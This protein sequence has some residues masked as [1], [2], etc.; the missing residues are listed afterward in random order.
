MAFHWKKPPQKPTKSHQKKTSKKDVKGH[1]FSAYEKVLAIYKNKKTSALNTWLEKRKISAPIIESAEICFSTPGLLT[2]KITSEKNNYPKYREL[3]GELEGS[4]LIR[5][6]RL[7]STVSGNHHLDIDEQYRDFFNDPRILLPIRDLNRRIVGF[8]GRKLDETSRAPKYLYTP[9][10]PKAQILYRAYEAFQKINS[11]LKNNDTPTLYICEGL[12]DALRL[13][14]L[15]FAAVSILGSKLSE[16]QAKTIAQLASTLPEI[17]PLQVRFFLDRDMAGLKGAASSIETLIKTD[18]DIRTEISFIWPNENHL[19]SEIA[20]GKDPDELF[21]FVED[22]KDAFEFLE[23]S[24]HPAAVAII[25]ER[26]KI[27]PLDVLD[28]S[29]WKSIP[30]GAKSRLSNH[31]AKLTN[32]ILSRVTDIHQ[33][34][35]KTDESWKSDITPVQQPTD[36]VSNQYFQ[37][38]STE[39]A[40]LRLNLAREVAHAGA[41][42]GE[43][44]SDIAGWRRISLAATAFNE[45]LSSRLTQN[46][47]QPIEPF[48]AAYVSR[49]FG[50][51]EE[52]LK[53]MPCPEDLII[54]QYLMN[55]LLTE[56]LDNNSETTYSSCIPAVR[57]YRSLNTTK[58]TGESPGVS[59]NETLSFAYQIDMDAIEGRAPPTVGG[60]FRPY[61][62]CW[63][64]FIS[65]LLNQGNKMDQ[66]HMVRLDLKR[67]YDNIKRSIIKATLSKSIN[68]AYSKLDN[69]EIF[70]PLFRPDKLL[71]ERQNAVVDYL[72]DQSFGFN[73]FH[74]DTG[75]LEQSDYEQGI[76]QGPVLSAWLGNALLFQL[77]NAFRKKL[78]E[79]NENGKTRAVYAR[80]VD[81]VVLLGENLD[82]LDV[83]RATTEDIA[84]SLGLEMISKESFAPMT[85]EEFSQH[86]T[87]GRALTASGPREEPVLFESTNRDWD[88]WQSE[89]MTRQTSLALLSDAR[90]YVVPPHI[91]QNQIFTALRAKDLR[92]SELKKAARWSWY[93]AA[94]ETEDS[95]PLDILTKYWNIWDAISAG[96]SFYL[97]ESVPWDDPAIYALEGLEALFERA[98]DSDQGLTAE[99]IRTKISCISK[100]AVAA[101]KFEFSRYFLSTT[102]H[103]VP[104]PP[105]WG[106][107][108]KKLRRMFIQRIICIQWKAAQLAKNLETETFKTPFVFEFIQSQNKTLQTSLKRSLI[109]YTDTWKKDSTA[110][111]SIG[112][113]YDNQRNVLG[114]AFLLIHQAIAVLSIEQPANTKD[115]LSVF[116]DDLQNINNRL[117]ITTPQ[118]KLTSDKFL[119]L[120][121]ELLRTGEE[122]EDTANSD[123]NGEIVLLALQ[124]LAAIA[125]RQSFPTL[126]ANRQHLFQKG[127]PKLPLPP[128]PGIPAKGLLLCSSS[129]NI[130]YWTKVTKIWWITLAQEDQSEQ[131][132]PMF[133][134]ANKDDPAVDFNLEWKLNLNGQLAVFEADWKSTDTF[135]A[136]I[137]PPSFPDAIENLTWVADTF[138]SIS[139]INED[140]FSDEELSQEYA[141]AWPYLI[142]NS[143]PNTNDNAPLKISLLTPSYPTSFLDGVAYIKDGTRGLRTFDIPELYGQYWRI[144]V[145][146]SELFGFRR[147]ID[148]FAALESFVDITPD[149]RDTLEPSAHLLRN[150]FRKLRGTY[151]N[152]QLLKQLPDHSIPATISRSLHLLR[153]FPK[154]ASSKKA[155]AYVLA[156]ET[157]SAAMYIRIGASILLESYGIATAFAER[158]AIRVTSQIPLSWSQRLATSTTTACYRRQREISRSYIDL[159]DRLE[160]LSSDETGH[161]DDANFQI[162][163]AGLRIASAASWLR[164]LAF[165]IQAS[166][167]EEDWPYP[168]DGDLA[169]NWQ[170][171]EQGFSFQNPDDSIDTLCANFRRFV[172]DGASQSSFNDITPFGWVVLVAGRLGLLGGE[173]KRPLETE[174]NTQ[175]IEQF[176]ILANYLS[177]PFLVHANNDENEWPFKFEREQIISSWNS[178]LFFESMRC[179]DEVELNLKLNTRS[180]VASWKFEPNTHSFSDATGE[181]WIVKKWQIAISDGYKPER[182]EHGNRILSKWNET[183]DSTGNLIFISA[184]SDRFKKL[185]IN[186]VQEEN[187]DSHSSNILSTPENA[188]KTV[189]TPT[190]TSE[191]GD[192]T[193]NITPPQAPDKTKVNDDI[194]PT[195]TI[196]PPTQLNYSWKDLQEQSWSL[197]ERRS[198][199]HTRIALMQWEVDESYHH[200][201]FDIEKKNI[202]WPPVTSPAAMEESKIEERRRKL[203]LEALLT[204]EKFRVDLLV[205]P[206]YSVRPDTVKWLQDILSRKPKC[207]AVLAGT[208]KVHGNIND[209]NFTETHHEIFGLTDHLKNFGTEST[210]IYLSPH[211][212]GE[213]SAMMTLL[214]P[215]DLISGDRIVCVFS[216]RKKYSS[217]AASEVFSP[218]LDKLRPLY[219]AENLLQEIES[220][221]ISGKR[222]NPST[223]ISPSAILQ[224][225]KKLRHLEHLAEFICSELFLP[226]SPVNYKALAAELHKLALRFGA[227][228]SLESAEQHIIEDLK[229]MADYLG[230]AGDGGERRSIITVPA[231]TNRSADYWVFGQS[232]LLSGGATTVFCN[233][234]KDKYAIGGSC[235]IGR[236][237]WVR[238]KQSVHA[239]TI[240]PYAGWSKGIYYNQAADALGQR[241]QAIVIADVDPSFMQE[242]RPRP[243]AL[244]VPLQ[245]VAYLPIVELKTSEESEFLEKMNEII[246][247]LKTSNMRGRIV[248]PLEAGLQDIKNLIS[249]HLHD[250]DTGS[251][252]SRFHHWEKYWRLNPISGIPPSITDWILIDSSARNEALP[253]IFVPEC[254]V[255]EQ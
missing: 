135:W 168:S 235:F 22:P 119:P 84:N 188:Y 211:I 237:S 75:N 218:L 76:P 93:L 102:D 54:Q 133:K 67:Y 127:E 139:R 156:S 82:V 230:I 136:L 163:L 113:Q 30:Y 6:T 155:V 247:I 226:M 104:T 34:S 189:A 242:G 101:C 115:P 236:N 57:H 64:E 16:Q 116:S 91:I 109:T 181:S 224:Y 14:A 13:E 202:S 174:W 85:T 187:V 88:M 58:T 83:L 38:I 12:F 161:F 132:V 131:Y 143:R 123:A 169:E 94:L 117:K 96:V 122:I 48:D 199:G 203:I 151:F 70:A 157:E 190:I 221:S 184:R 160:L 35:S 4:G 191:T 206:E 142:T 15:G 126:L 52:R 92:P 241:E 28:N 33:Q 250:R 180:V 107:G 253:T 214:A 176:K 17:I 227:T 213:H 3:L 51:S 10:L 219:S 41:N 26:L 118:F 23:R 220:R 8:A 81:D 164:E 152:G 19:N 170:L 21:K 66:V 120:L 65:S 49:G 228:M 121:G 234:V 212:S 46:Q 186:S 165:C 138:D 166:G 249:K 1:H 175:T 178:S 100:L 105:G 177:L 245:L 167:V 243:Q 25:A 171:E 61:F 55:E 129:E 255:P 59:V 159:R 153:N 112:T 106:A 173:S 254:N 5:A 69:P 108:Y 60:M 103:A 71:D 90:L 154:E 149:I 205:L 209:A 222:Q 198:P 62:E 208:Y 144:G 32:N 77:D 95:D 125:P 36:L 240:T 45:G 63:K 2:N 18:Q 146:L 248:S 231:M 252:A 225:S 11:S 200:P 215:L 37:E 183:T 172:S 43:V 99:E 251:F 194:D 233:A 210:N 42:K 72:L 27:L 238:E 68:A 97:D 145:S 207:P 20:L 87:S 110:L 86:L 7:K 148:Q 162:L 89:E 150:I 179:L 216:R 79:L 73:Y 124:T 147:D 111:A 192:S 130:G 196:P 217:L 197:R 229:S 244:A 182:V 134:I 40:S 141:S 9:S 74:P 24:T 128:L 193:K 56:R 29:R 80:Y 204:C 98:N 78:R 39:E 140:L 114:D 246:Q 137:S 53:T 239:D 185:L 50:K 195:T 44:L 201:I 31:L 158:I 223:P 232:T 47:F